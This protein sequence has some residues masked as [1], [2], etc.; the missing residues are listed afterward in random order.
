MGVEP[1]AELF[2]HPEQEDY[3]QRRYLWE[4]WTS[5]LEHAPT[6]LAYLREHGV[7]AWLERYGLPERLR[8]WAEEY[9]ADPEDYVPLGWDWGDTP[10]LLLPRLPQYWEPF[11]EYDPSSMPP[12]RWRERAI[13][14]LESYMQAV[15]E[16]YARAG[17]QK[18]RVKYNP[19]HFTWLSL[20]LEGLSWAQIANRA[21][22]PVE[23]AAVRLAVT[24]LA[25]RLG[26]NISL[27]S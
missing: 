2:T 7:S 15:E 16:S 22:A 20:R 12:H 6:C 21:A 26:M 17:W 27:Q 24:R 25:E 19:E 11:P 3:L 10:P 4:L 23:D 5:L 18:A 14:W 9:R 8:D 1:V 13:A